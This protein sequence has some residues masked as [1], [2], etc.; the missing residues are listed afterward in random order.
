MQQHEVA[1]HL[2][3]VALPLYAWRNLSSSILIQEGIWS[4]KR[5][6]L[7]KYATPSGCDT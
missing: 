5:S 4:Q 6:Y 7:I 1:E 3:H 2:W